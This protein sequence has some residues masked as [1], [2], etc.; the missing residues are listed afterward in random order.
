MQE[1]F[2]FTSV[3][4][5]SP[6]ASYIGGK[7][8]L[9]QRVA[10]VIE[11]IPHSVYAE[12]FVGMGGVF[13]RRRLVPKCEVINDISGDVIT[14]FRILQRHYPQFMETLKFQITSRRE[15][16]RL[17]ACDPSTL[18]DLERAAR[19]L[20]LQRLAFGGKVTGRNYGVDTGG[21]ARFNVT[22]LGPLLEEIHERLAGVQ[23]E[24]LSWL[25]FIDRY[26]APGTLF[27]MDPPY[28]GCETDYGKDVFSRSDF[29]RIAARMADIKGRFMISLNDTPEVRLIFSAFKI[30]DVALTYT[31]GSGHAKPVGEVIIM[32]RKLPA[33]PNMPE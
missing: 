4:P 16:E 18:T 12:P 30:C 29:E 3:H 9:A 13:F 24:N 21:S 20:Y 14:L 6:A 28:F 10:S 25:D 11:Q 27:Y 26:D 7:K 8:Q 17:K 1:G 32:D 22:R 5:V 31:I 23:I 2:S 19:F 15:F 33:V